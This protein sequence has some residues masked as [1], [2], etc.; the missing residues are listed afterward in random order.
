MHPGEDIDL[1]SD[2]S[3]LKIARSTVELVNSFNEWSPTNGMCLAWPPA[4]RVVG[5]VTYLLTQFQQAANATMMNNLLP[6]IVNHPNSGS[7]CNMENS[8]ATVAI[9]DLLVSRHGHGATRAIRYLPNGWPQGQPVSFS[10]VRVKGG[11]LASGQAVGA[12]PGAQPS[13]AKLTIVS[14]FV[15]AVN[16]TVINPFTNSS[17]PVVVNAATS[18]PV[19]LSWLEPDRFTFVTPQGIVFEIRASA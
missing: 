3:L 5:N 17:T 11:H 10:N 8:G 15:G 12:G 18:E 13:W 6:N 9:N 7:G 16:A 19:A 1:D 4:S 2:T 14:T